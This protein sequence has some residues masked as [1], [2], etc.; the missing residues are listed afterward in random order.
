MAGQR[1]RIK[2]GAATLWNLPAEGEGRHRRQL[3]EK[4]VLMLGDIG[5]VAVIFPGGFGVASVPG[6][7]S[8]KP[9]PRFC[10]F[11]KPRQPGDPGCLCVI[12]DEKTLSGVFPW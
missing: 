3:V 4:S 12:K 10:P 8:V 5:G 2:I 11:V 9:R 1:K 7:R 6:G